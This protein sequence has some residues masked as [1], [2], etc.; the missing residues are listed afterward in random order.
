MILKIPE[1]ILMN[2]KQYQHLSHRLVLIVSFVGALLIQLSLP[3]VLSFIPSSFVSAAIVIDATQPG[4]CELPDGDIDGDE[5]ITQDIPKSLGGSGGDINLGD[6]TSGSSPNGDPCDQCATNSNAPLVADPINVATG[7]QYENEVDYQ[8]RDPFPLFLSRYYNSADTNLSTLGVGWRI[9]YSRAIATTS[10]TNA[11]KAIR[12]DGKSL[13][14]TLTNG[15]WQA[16]GDINTKL[17][18]LASGWS[19]TT[20][21]DATETYNDNGNLIAITNRIGSVQT[22]SYDSQG[23]LLKIT[24]SFGHSLTYAY[25]GASNLVYSVTVPNGGVYSYSYDTN[26]NLVSV[27]YPDQS[28]RQFVYENASFPNSVT[29]VIDEKNTRFSTIVYDDKGR[30]I[31]SELAGGVNKYKLDYS[32]LTNGYVPV[33]DALGAVRTSTFTNINGSVFETSMAYNCPDCKTT[34]AAN[35]T[36]YDINGNLSS[37]TDFNGNTTTYTYDTTRNLELSRTEAS[38]T[39]QARTIKTA[40]HP[41]FRLPTQ[42]VEPT[43]TTNFTYDSKGNVLTQAIADAQNTR[44]ISMTYNS[45]GQVLT[46]DGPRTD[47]QDITSFTYDAQGN[48]STTTNALGQV[49]AVT[50]Y[51]PDGQ[52]LTVQDPNGLVTTFQYNA[53]GQ[54]VSSTTDSETTSYIYDSA[55]LLSSVSLPNGAVYYYNYDPAHR[56]TQIIDSFGNKIV[57][58]LDALGNRITEDVYDATNQLAKTHT[59]KFNSLSKLSASIDSKKQATTFIYDQNNNVIGVADPL[60]QLTGNNYDALNRLSMTT[61]ANNGITK[62]LYDANDKLAQINDPLG[63]STSYTRNGLGD[64][65]KLTSPDTGVT[66]KTY[67]A[68]GNVLTST[69]ARGMKIQYSY[70]ALN[71]VSKIAYSDGK[72][73]N[74]SYDNGPNAQGRL[75]QIS[76]DTGNTSYAYDK[77]GRVINKTQA[78]GTVSLSTSYSYD[79][80]GNLS[81]MTYPSGAMLT[82]HY[83]KGR[84][85]G[86][87]RSATPLLSNIQYTAF[88]EVN[89]WLWGNRQPYQR[90]FDLDGRLDSYPIDG[91]NTLNLTYDAVGRILSYASPDAS[92]NQ[93]FSYDALG[94]VTIVLTGQLQKI[95]YDANG[96]RNSTS[97]GSAITSYSYVTGSNKL[98]ALSSGASNTAYV[99]DATGNLTGDGTLNF[100]YDARGRLI[101]AAKTGMTADY[102]INGL[103]QRVKKA[104]GTETTLFAYDEAGHLIGEYGSANG[105]VWPIHETVFLG[106]IPVTEMTLSNYYIYADHLNTPRTIVNTGGTVLWQWGGDPFGT[107]KPVGSRYNPRFPGQYFDAETGLHYNGFRDYDPKIGRYIESD[108]VGLDGGVNSYAYVGNNP[109]S[110]TDSLGLMCNDTGCWTTPGE[111]KILN[112]EGYQGYYKEACANGDAYTCFAQHIAANDNLW[113]YLATKRLTNA[114]KDQNS[115]QCI[116][117][118]T[119][120]N[121]I[122]NDLANAYANYLPDSQENARFP[123]AEGVAKFHWE[124]FKKFGL[125]PETFGGTPFGSTPFLTWIWCPNCR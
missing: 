112:Q 28:K 92:Q 95:D 119:I 1:N 35:S 56:L 96:N 19:Y 124:E 108:P 24:N 46:I 22:L 63:L 102:S 12:D 55:Q 105:V 7:N 23:R 8:S 94:R 6:H 81:S 27:T 71:R 38:G 31:S 13:T 74:L 52:P 89:G 34:T 49:T 50:A 59:Q 37:Q 83:D 62:F 117:E 123:T 85:T 60:A 104:V 53:R 68:A 4:D 39:P 51:N 77:H 61:D 116:D 11:V 33:T 100:T 75:T 97:T 113:G 109:I 86:I 79:A 80:I 98:K 115:N 40:W 41:I 88:G 45:N 14:F 64:I 5:C 78:I 18:K 57:Y 30:A 107:G 114:L 32:Q 122:R 106:N 82:L 101:K 42:I 48:L 69:D 54:L 110:H 118:L 72:F 111:R 125:P 47:V 70:D 36:L 103:G 99:Y 15:V 43:R 2:I 26:N 65:V 121:Q 17:V 76:D 91:N 3:L 90:H 9:S 87:D 25:K 16:T 21:L 84:L 44:S 10:N 66:Q 73:V 58:T 29:G 120:L 20:G 67:D 93:Q